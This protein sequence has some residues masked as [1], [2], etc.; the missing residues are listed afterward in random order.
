M[1]YSPIFDRRKN[2]SENPSEALRLQLEHVMTQGGLEATALSDKDGLLL[3]G[4]GEQGVCEELGAVAPV[5]SAA[6]FGVSMPPLLSGGE[7]AVRS[8]TP[9]GNGLFVSV[10]GGGVARDALL[11]HLARG[12]SRILA[13]N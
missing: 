11:D 6:P 9:H 8:A 4:A 10:L 13:T 2:R 12:V 5:I 3:A 7:V 1:S